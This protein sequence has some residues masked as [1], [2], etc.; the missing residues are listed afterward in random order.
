VLKDE[1]TPLGIL[2]QQLQRAGHDSGNGTHSVTRA[3]VLALM[4]VVLLLASEPSASAPADL[5][6]GVWAGEMVAPEWPGYFTV[7][8][9]G[10]AA[11]DDASGDLYF[12]LESE[13]GIKLEDVS[14]IGDAVRFRARKD[15]QLYSFSG[16]RSGSLIQGNVEIGP[17]STHFVLQHLERL[18][19]ADLDGYVGTYVADD[20]QIMIARPYT[21]IMFLDRK[22]GRMGFL[23]PL[24]NSL[25]FSGPS[26]GVH[27]PPSLTVQ[28]ERDA[29]GAVTSV[30]VDEH[31][32]PP[33][34]GRRIAPFASQ[35]LDF[36]NAGAKL[37]G[38][39]Y[40]PNRKPPY[41]A[42]MLIAGSNYQTR[43]A[44]N[45]F[46][47]WVGDV[48]LR[49]GFAVFAYDKRGAGFSTGTRSDEHSLDDAIAGFR[50]LSAQPNTRA[51]CRGIW[52]I[53][54]GGMVAPRVAQSVPGVAFI[55]NT[56]GAVVSGNV[57]EV[58]RTAAEMRADGFSEADIRDAVAFQKLK[59][60]YATTGQGWD[61]YAAAVE[62]YKDRKWFPDPYVGPPTEK[63]SPAFRFWRDTGNDAPADA[64]KNFHGQALYIDGE[65]ETSQDPADNIQAFREA[66]KIAGN[67]QSETIVVKDADHSMLVDRNGGNRT[68]RLITHFQMDYFAILESWISTVRCAQ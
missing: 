11:A 9:P 34:L 8:F 68:D 48:F 60:S 61:E 13:T 19:I 35:E 24:G 50:T 39:I 65:Y 38:T 22:T 63:D 25:F 31:N 17:A 20:R 40:F 49:K 47:A 26:K 28:F 57:Q 23:W 7:A 44:Q 46:L 58:Q 37:A 56:S 43:V 64:W 15:L 36:T 41:P 16:R 42:V 14:V 3:L 12:P 29:S 5:S 54:Q 21:Y 55:V 18:A 51:Q 30:R 2:R 10:A 45:A 32:K 66:M 67:R 59:F 33:I 62:K 53:S 6:N 1:P 52:G 4:G 27:Y